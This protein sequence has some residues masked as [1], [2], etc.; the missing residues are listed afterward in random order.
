M[1]ERAYLVFAGL[2]VA[3]LV[4]YYGL[5]FGAPWFLSRYLF[6][7]AALVAPLWGLA[8]LAIWRRVVADGATSLGAATGALLL[9]V[10]AYPNLRTY[11]AGTSHLHF[12]V[13]E[14]VA[15]HVEADEWIAAVQTGTI[16]YFHDR[17]IN[18]DGKVN[19]EA[20]AAML[21]GKLGDYLVESP[22]RYFADWAQATADWYSDP[23]HPEVRAHFELVVLDHER[24][25]G[26]LARRG[27]GSS[28]PAGGER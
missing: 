1:R 22:A 8:A 20:L 16:G 5:F 25:L 12:Q 17:T 24:N 27:E 2:Y 9:A 13:V 14:W 4:G 26:V 6:P 15:E 19:P 3:G 10:V 21:D 23:N 11:R 7:L 28:V 18:L